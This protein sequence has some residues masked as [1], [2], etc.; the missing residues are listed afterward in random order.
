[1][2]KSVRLSA[3]GDVA[4]IIALNPTGRHAQIWQ[5]LAKADLSM[6]NLE[7]PLT[8]RTH[9]AYKAFNVRAEPEV[10][11]SLK[12]LGVDVATIANNHT[13]DF[14]PAGLLDT[15]GALQDA[16]IACVGGGS[17]LEEA[18][19][20]HTDTYGGL[21]IGILGLCSALPTGYAASHGT[22]GIAPLRVDTRFFIDYVTLSECP[23]MSPWVETSVV[24]ADL[25]RV[26]ALISKARQDLD[27][28]IVQIHWGVPHGWAPT[29]RGPL[30]DYQRP[31]GH[32]LIDAGVDL[33]IGHHPHVFHGVEKYRNGIIAYSL[34]HFLFHVF[35]SIAKLELTAS[36]PPYATE[37]LRTGEGKD[38]LL[39]EADITKHGIREVRFIPVRLDD[40]FEPGA[41]EGPDANIVLE[42]L[43]NYSR[44]LDTQLE[45]VGAEAVLR[46]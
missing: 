15:I 28:L 24:Q 1:M 35:G 44:P 46:M 9:G 16:S 41:L 40:R 12:R 31:V 36:Y 37:A 2:D 14:G 5:R 34:G 17:T 23:G 39:L 21:K 30:A 45:I 43:I 13:V 29:Y 38:A 42:R 20:I 32:A 8:F 22:P 3:V 19:H 10:A 4:P 27:C 26:C 25:D 18:L 7:V 6:I 33:V 11:K